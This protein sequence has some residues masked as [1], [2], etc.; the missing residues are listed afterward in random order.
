MCA[1]YAIHRFGSDWRKSRHVGDLTTCRKTLVGDK[2][3]EHNLDPED[4]RKT[5][6]LHWVLGDR[7]G[8][9]GR[10]LTTAPPIA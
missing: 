2:A 10:K 8:A 3:A 5:Q 6:P 4:P 9:L 1:V 7:F